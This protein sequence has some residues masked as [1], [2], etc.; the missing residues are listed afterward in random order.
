MR[1]E[2]KTQKKKKH[3]RQWYGKHVVEDDFVFVCMNSVRLSGLYSPTKRVSGQ[4]AGFFI[5]KVHIE[6]L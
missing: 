6:E 2:R 3:K 4:K 5:D 1:T